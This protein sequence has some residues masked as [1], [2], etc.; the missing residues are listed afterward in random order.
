M[1]SKH[2][3]SPTAEKHVNF[4]GPNSIEAKGL[5][6]T[7]SPESFNRFQIWR[8]RGLVLVTVENAL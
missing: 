4:L 2:F 6:Q 8:G 3:A 1:D 5:I 7:Q